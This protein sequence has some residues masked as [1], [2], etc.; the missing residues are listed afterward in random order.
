MGAIAHKLEVILNKIL[1]L[2]SRS[3]KLA[4][5]A[6][7]SATYRKLW[8]RFPTNHIQ[9][10]VKVPGEDATR[11]EGIIE[12]IVKMREQAQLLDD[13]CGNA[14]AAPEKKVG[15]KATAELFFRPA[16]RFDECRICVH[17]SA[18]STAHSDLFENHLSNCATGCPKF[19]EATTELRKNLAK[20]VKLCSQCFHPEVIFS[21]PHL[22][23]CVFAKKKNKYSCTADGCKE[24]CIE[25]F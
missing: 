13:E 8:A 25:L 16:R 19:M 1:D 22:K 21:P 14:A 5:E 18:T 7:S 3:S 12:K 11:L 4:H 23:E 17:L 10:L 2:S 15:N 6:F 20:K 9:K 24:H